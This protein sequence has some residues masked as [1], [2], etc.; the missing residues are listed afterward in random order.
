MIP[1]M[2]RLAEIL[3]TPWFFRRLALIWAMCL[4]TGIVLLTFKQLGLVDT[5]RATL[6]GTFFGVLTLMIGFYHKDRLADAQIHT[7][8]EVVPEVNTPEIPV[9]QSNE[10]DEIV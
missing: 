3:M 7:E 6:I 1:A 10:P 4:A 8:D 5:A 2:K 9:V